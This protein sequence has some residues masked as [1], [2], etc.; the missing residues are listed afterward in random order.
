MRPLVAQCHLGLGRLHRRAG[1]V[2]AARSELETALALFRSMGMDTPA[3]RA[4]ADL[5]GCVA[6]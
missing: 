6:P 1:R 4:E 3:R 2:T 5:A